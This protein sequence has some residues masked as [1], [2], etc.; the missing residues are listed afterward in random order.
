MWRAQQRQKQAMRK[1]TFAT[2][3]L[4]IGAVLGLLS[5]IHQ[6]SVSGL[7]AVAASPG[8]SSWQPD[9][10]SFW[11][12]YA[13]QRFREDGAL[14]PPKSVQLYTRSTDDDGNQLRAECDYRFSGP[15]I[16][17]RWWTVATLRDTA[18]AAADVLAAGSALVGQDNVFEINLSRQP[19]S[20]NWL[21]VPDSG[22]YLLRV[23]VNDAI[24]TVH[25]PGI[26]K[27]GC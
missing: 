9:R 6:M 25:L 23:V 15:A 20:G 26:K 8:W 12:I 5:A 17:S 1:L 18:S 19:Q 4:I 22:N 24:D 7:Y 3:I 27:L 2:V 14:P 11:Q 10:P 13:T 21:K 16:K